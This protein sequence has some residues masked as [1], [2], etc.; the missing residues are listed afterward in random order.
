[1]KKCP[2]CAEMIQPEAQVCRYCGRDL[3]ATDL[4]TELA[5][6]NLVGLRQRLATLDDAAIAALHARGP[7]VTANPSAWAVLD[8]EHRKRQ[9]GSQG[10]GPVDA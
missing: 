7:G 2:F 4:A 3:P 8:A 1:M 5:G 9:A 10:F 6:R